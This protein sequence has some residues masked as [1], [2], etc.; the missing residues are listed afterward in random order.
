MRVAKGI[1]DGSIAA[2]NEKLSCD[3]HSLRRISQSV[4]AVISSTFI[5]S[6]TNLTETLLACWCA[7]IVLSCEQYHP[8]PSTPPLITRSLSPVIEAFV[9][10]NEA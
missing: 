8:Y 1:L 4:K 3:S 7:I 10:N 6:T 2:S 9:A 5:R